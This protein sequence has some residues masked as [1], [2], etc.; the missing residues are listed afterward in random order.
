LEC[1]RRNS[2]HYV[3]RYIG[4]WLGVERFEAG[5]GG[6]FGGFAVAATSPPTLPFENED[7]VAQ[8]DKSGESVF[9]LCFAIVDKK[10]SQRFWL[11]ASAEMDGP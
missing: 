4:R 11:I 6:F 10:S 3:E 8:V 9:W 5:E 2:D 7:W 1:T